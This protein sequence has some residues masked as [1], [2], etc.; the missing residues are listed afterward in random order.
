VF[1]NVAVYS[2]GGSNN[3]RICK[4]RCHT[5]KRKLLALYCT[6]RD[7]CVKFLSAVLVKVWVSGLDVSEV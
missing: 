1:V 4:R 7:K 5:Y 3:L 2:Q 6:L